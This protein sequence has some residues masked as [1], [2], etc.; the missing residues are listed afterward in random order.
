MVEKIL[1]V[2]LAYKR[3]M[4]KKLK[5]RSP[6]ARIKQRQYYKTHLSKIRLQRR[7]YIKK[8]SLFLKSRKMFKRTK[9][10]WMTH[11]K[12]KPPKSHVKKAPKSTVKKFQPPKKPKIRRVVM[13]KPKVRKV[14]SPKRA[15][16]QTGPKKK[17]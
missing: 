12:T 10:A 13:P 2:I 15:I 14:T 16:G 3:R 8:N 9:P 6:I 11:K 1:R 5:R 17:R 7:R 4:V